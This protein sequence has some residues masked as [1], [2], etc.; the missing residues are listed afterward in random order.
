MQYILILN[1]FIYL[2]TCQ[3]LEN[4]ADICTSDYVRQTE[5]V[6]WFAFCEIIYV[7]DESGEFGHQF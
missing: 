2:E 4:I 1:R 7:L 6:P 5:G 3:F